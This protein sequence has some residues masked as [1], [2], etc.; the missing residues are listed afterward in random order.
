MTRIAKMRPG[1][2]VALGLGALAV[3]FV[4]G[5]AEAQLPSA[6]P[7]ALGMGENHTAAARGFNSVAWNPAN[8]GLSG[9][10]TTSLAFFPVRGIGGLYP[11]GL[12]DLKEH[13][14]GV[15]SDAVKEEWLERIAEAGG[16]RGAAG[17]DL[18]FVALSVGRVGFQLSTVAR[19]IGDLGPDAAEL[20]LYG[21]AGRTGEPR[22][23]G[24]EGSKF[25]M[26]VASTAAFSYAQPLPLPVGRLALGATV[27]YTVGHLLATGADAGSQL[28]SDPLSVQV[29]FPIVHSDTTPQFDNGH[30]VGLDLGA[31]FE[32]GPWTAAV[33]VRNAINTFEWDASKFFYRPARAVFDA[34]TSTSEFD[35]L[36]LAEAP[37]ALRQRLDESGY[38]K[39]IA[40]G[41]A[42]RPASN[43][44]LA[45]DIRHQLG[46][47]LELGNETHIGAGLEFRPF[48]WLPLQAGVA[49]VPD[50]VQF[51]GGAG[52]RIG[53][54][55][56][57]GAGLL[58]TGDAGDEVVG[59]F[60]FSFWGGM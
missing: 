56:L 57:Q 17:A 38:R 32:L 27:K 24:L 8:L 22:D 21:N 12:T 5:P 30:G 49:H 4:V 6:S 58:R 14:D 50:G 10:P 23:F 13:Q 47:G 42:F 29:E 59:M 43:F 28:N 52:L 16:E 37:T 33:A 1:M 46:D 40:A 54:I 55:H 51:T 36:P 31:A 19:A 20:I 25:D 35:A 7:V 44:T 26:V 15:L 34:D 60:S 39:E 48:S 9:N 18:T 45:A 11:V 41:V 53:G 2:S 3:L